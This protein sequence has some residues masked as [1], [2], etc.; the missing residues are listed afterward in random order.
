MLEDPSLR[1]RDIDHA[2]DDRVRHMDTLRAEFS[3][4]RLRQSSKGKLATGK[5]RKLSGSSDTRCSTGENQ[6]WWVRKRVLGLEQQGERTLG[7]VKA[8]LSI[9]DNQPFDLVLI[10]SREDPI[11][12]AWA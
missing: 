8:A 11:S 7:E 6:G 2:V 12:T 10:I 4:Q 5:C 3:G 9:S 1:A